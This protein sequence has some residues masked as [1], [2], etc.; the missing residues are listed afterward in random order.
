MRSLN[1]AVAQELDGGAVPLLDSRRWTAC[2]LQ[3]ERFVSQALHAPQAGAPAELERAEP[4]R[5]ADPVQ[6][7]AADIRAALS[8]LDGGVG[9]VT[10]RCGSC[11]ID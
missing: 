8:L 1:N 4:I 7:A 10:P 6:S 3:N 5:V 11:G 2:V 9:L